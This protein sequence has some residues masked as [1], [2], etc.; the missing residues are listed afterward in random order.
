MECSHEEF[1]V[2]RT[3]GREITARCLFCGEVFSFVK[4]KRIFLPVIISR[5]EKTFKKKLEIEGDREITVGEVLDVGGEDVEVHAIEVGNRRVEREKASSITTLWGISL[6]F[7]QIVGISLH[8]PKKTASY[9]AKVDR[10]KVFGIGD[11]FQIGGTSFEITSI[12]TTSGKR[13]KAI[14]DEIK[15][16]YGRP[17][18]RL[19]RELLEAYHG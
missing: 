1:E 15:R 10:E 18:N 7:P 8:F 9:K 13:K 12:M 16:I 5:H 17:S 6:T 4:E 14:G 3:R 2:L 19:A 11:V